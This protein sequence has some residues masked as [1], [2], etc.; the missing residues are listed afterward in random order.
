MHPIRIE[1]LSAER[2]AELDHANR[3]ARDGR[4]RVR[5]LTVLLAAER[6]MVATEIA[7]IIRQH[8]RPPDA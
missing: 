5:A 1:R 8:T 6:G 2:H 4:L 3:T 7:A